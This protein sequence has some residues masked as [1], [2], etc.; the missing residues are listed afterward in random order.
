LFERLKLQTHS[1]KVCR[2]L[3]GKMKLC[4]FRLGKFQEQNTKKK[5]QKE[6]RKT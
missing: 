1:A 3:G 5:K 6:E 2:G 4:H